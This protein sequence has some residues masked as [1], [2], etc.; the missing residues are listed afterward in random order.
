VALDAATLDRIDE[1]VQP[2]VTINPAD[3]SYGEQLLKPGL[4]GAEKPEQIQ[5][6]IT[7]SSI[8]TTKGPFDWFAGDVYV[9]RHVAVRRRARSLHARRPA[10]GA[11]TAGIRTRTADD[12]RDRGRRGCQGEGGRVEIIRPGD[13]VFFEPG[14]NHWHGAAP[15]ASGP[16]SP[17]SR[18]TSPAARRT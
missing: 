18:P 10:P 1:I 8:E 13:G 9:G 17:C 7:R 12:L 2:G 14:E 5:M 11:R 3:N 4:L 6:Q 16:T 15:A